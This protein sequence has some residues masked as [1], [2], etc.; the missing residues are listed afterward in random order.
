MIEPHKQQCKHCN[1]QFEA[2][3]SFDLCEQC[4]ELSKYLILSDVYSSNGVELKTIG[5]YEVLTDGNGS[6]K[7]HRLMAC[8][9]NNPHDVFN[10]SYMNVHHR[11]TVPWDNRRENLLLLRARYHRNFHENTPWEE[12]VTYY[13]KQDVSDAE[14][15][16]KEKFYQT[17]TE[18][19]LAKYS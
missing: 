11:N 2:C 7:I 6:V 14:L 17:L 15:Q 3:R 19:Y 1:T 10:K 5:G 4:G 12:I 9:D 8:L 18:K 16:P 13:A